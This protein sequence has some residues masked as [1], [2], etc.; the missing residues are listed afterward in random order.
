MEMSET[1]LTGFDGEYK[2]DQQ[3]RLIRVTPPRKTMGRVYR[4]RDGRTWR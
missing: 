1:R 3:G 4:T 2:L